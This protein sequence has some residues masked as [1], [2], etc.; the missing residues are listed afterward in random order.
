MLFFS[1]K[2][3]AE[4]KAGAKNSWFAKFPQDI[5]RCEKLTNGDEKILEKDPYVERKEEKV[6]YKA[7]FGDSNEKVE[8]TPKTPK[9]PAGAKRKAGK[10]LFCLNS[11]RRCAHQRQLM[12]I[13]GLDIGGALSRLAS[14]QE[15]NQEN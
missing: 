3:R 2:N 7:I 6:D 13:I 10:Y 11:Y 12:Q 4:V 15:A 1:V 9:T 5:V 8:K 14:Q